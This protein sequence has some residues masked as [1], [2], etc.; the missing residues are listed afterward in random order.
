MMTPNTSRREEVTVATQSEVFRQGAPVWIRILGAVIVIACLGGAILGLTAANGDLGI[1]I[2]I[3]G[4]LVGAALG[5]AISISNIAVSV[6]G[7][8]IAVGLW[9]L[10][11]RTLTHEEIAS[12]ALVENVHPVRFGG[13]GYRR[14]P[15]GRIGLLWSGG[16]GV[17]IATTGGQRITVVLD[18]AEELHAA[19]IRIS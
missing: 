13:T 5:V 4:L 6:D 7:R 15:G 8:Q 10:Y 2:P 18:H 11:G 16:T 3:S 14:V 19:L 1:L 12:C 9:P 17:E